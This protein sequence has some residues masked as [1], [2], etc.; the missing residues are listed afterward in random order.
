MKIVSLLNTTLERLL[1]CLNLQKVLKKI[2]E[3]SDKPHKTNSRSGVWDL[4]SSIYLTFQRQSFFN[5]LNKGM[6][7]FSD[8]KLKL[9]KFPA[10][11][12]A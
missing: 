5:L 7:T 9:D 3:G 11:N 1:V 6:T 2:G 8:C 10:I 4:K 12:K